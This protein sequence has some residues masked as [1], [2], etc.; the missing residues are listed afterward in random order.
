[1][2]RKYADRPNWT[3]ILEK[4]YKQ[5][6][7]NE[8]DFRGHLTLLTLKQVK[9]DLSV[10]YN[11][12]VVR[13]VENGSEWMMHFP[14]EG[15]YAVVTTF[16]PQGEVVQWYFDI[17]KEKGL[18]E[19]GI[20]YIEDLYLDLVLLP[21]GEVFVLDEDELKEAWESGTITQADFD[22]AHATAAQL[23]ERIRAGT[24]SIVK[25]SKRYWDLIK[26]L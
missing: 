19:E 1:M 6:Y 23:I 18:T 10:Q 15:L 25:E 13:I 14:D 20:P 22:T 9:E 17:I 11:A 24:L 16:N 12:H 4:G 7:L 21:N 26:S 5:T 8:P 3:R 2:K